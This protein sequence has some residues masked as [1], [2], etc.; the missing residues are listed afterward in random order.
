MS[1]NNAEN[2]KIALVYQPVSLDM[3]ERPPPE[4]DY[5]KYLFGLPILFPLLCY[6]QNHM[7]SRRRQTAITITGMVIIMTLEKLYTNE[8]IR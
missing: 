8:Y 5:N 7:M 6:G 4:I 1:D 2:H 3:L